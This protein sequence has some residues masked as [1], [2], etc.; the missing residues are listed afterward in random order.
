MS[1]LPRKARQVAASPTPSLWPATRSYQTSSTSASTPRSNN[2][3]EFLQK[4]QRARLP[5]PSPTPTLWSDTGSCQTSA[6]SV[7]TRS[8]SSINA[9]QKSLLH[10]IFPQLA[11]HPLT[12]ADG[13]YA[14]SAV[15]SVPVPNA[16]DHVAFISEGLGL[17]SSNSQG[18]CRVPE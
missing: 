7:S 1:T 15:A 2:S 11:T 6:T 16:P 4:T 18:S 8:N 3:I 9:V 10:L 5:A 17:Q 12:P 14:T 13:L